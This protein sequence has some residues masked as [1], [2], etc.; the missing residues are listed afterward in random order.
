[1]NTSNTVDNTV[2]GRPRSK[3]VG[4]TEVDSKFA[5]MLASRCVD[6]FEDFEATGRAGAGAAVPEPVEIVYEES[7]D[8]LDPLFKNIV[9]I[10]IKILPPG[11]A[12]MGGTAHVLMSKMFGIKPLHYL[13]NIVKRK[14]GDEEQYT[15]KRDID[16]I[17]T[18]SM[19]F[20]DIRYHLE[21]IGQIEI[22][23]TAQSYNGQTIHH[24]LRQIRQLTSIKLTIP[25][26]TDAIKSMISGMVSF[27]TP[28]FSKD[29]FEKFP[30][31]F[32]IDMDFVEVN[33]RDV[34]ELANH[35]LV[36]NE[37]RMYALVIKQKRIDIDI[38]N[39]RSGKDVREL[40]PV[41]IS[42]ILPPSLT[43][44]GGKVV[45]ALNALFDYV[46][47]VSWETAP[48]PGR[49]RSGM[50][51]PTTTTEP[52]RVTYEMDMIVRLANIHSDHAVV[53]VAT[54][55]FWVPHIVYDES[56]T[57]E[58]IRETFHFGKLL[59]DDADKEEFRSAAAKRIF[60]HIHNECGCCICMSSLVEPGTSF[61]ALPC[62]CTS[63]MHLECFLLNYLSPAVLQVMNSVSGKPDPKHVTCPLCQKVWWTAKK[64]TSKV[65]F[66]ALQNEY[67]TYYTVEE[68]LQSSIFQLYNTK[69]YGQLISNPKSTDFWDFV[70]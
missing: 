23:N 63:V 47:G 16:V 49:T 11:A 28:F 32:I 37:L 62:G 45:V 58:K 46:K 60:D 52:L 41:R 61:V 21:Q 15:F 25:L 38:F 5:A 3:S 36:T 51:I 2:K 44:M 8:V 4:E 42:S 1:M 69:L 57:V 27:F 19:R 33:V 43:N 54:P 50:V 67:S 26:R 53:H 9:D 12:I 64:P 66:R 59:S 65:K 55:D 39:S 31:K 17:L 22:V 29:L 14:G 18:R 70:E 24:N 35:W 68:L 30:S 7:P 20:S 48:L 13:T 10:L 40:I 56:V 34:S 6:A